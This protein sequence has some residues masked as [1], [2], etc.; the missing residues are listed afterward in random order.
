MSL[1]YIHLAKSPCVVF[2]NGL[3]QVTPPS[4]IMLFR[5]RRSQDA[6]EKEIG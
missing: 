6:P 5:D 1:I 3:Y 2:W 4:I